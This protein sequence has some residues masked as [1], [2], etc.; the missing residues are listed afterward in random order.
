[1]RKL[2]VSFFSVFV[3]S[4]ALMSS[5][6][7]EAFDETCEC[8]Y[9]S[10]H[11]VEAE[12]DAD[13]VDLILLCVHEGHIHLFNESDGAYG[14]IRVQITHICNISCDHVMDWKLE[15]SYYDPTNGQGATTRTRTGSMVAGVVN[16]EIISAPL[17]YVLEARLIS[18]VGGSSTTSDIVTMTF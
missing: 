9:D 17:G 10:D 2:F 12:T 8:T 16:N 15:F 14:K 4:F 3:I 1:M 13:T 18:S 11:V 6:Y 7:A 5:A